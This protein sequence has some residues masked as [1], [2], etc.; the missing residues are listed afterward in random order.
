MKVSCPHC[1]AAYHVDDHRIPASGA[2][3]RCP[4]CRGTFPVRHVADGEV[5]GAVPLPA[6]TGVPAPAAVTF[7]AGTPPDR[8]PL[9]APESPSASEAPARGDDDWSVPLPAPDGA[10][11]SAI[12][13]S[14]N[15]SAGEPS[16]FDAAPAEPYGAAEPSDFALED[17]AVPLPEPAERSYED[18]FAAPAGP[19]EAAAPTAFGDIELATP[20]PGALVPPPPDDPFAPPPIPR[21]PPLR[22]A[23]PPATAP[24]PGDDLEALFGEE[25]RGAAAPAAPAPARAFAGPA[26]EPGATLLGSAASR[27]KVR[28]SSGRVFG[29]FAEEQIADML[30]KGE[31]LGNE[32]VS[33]D[34]GETW[35]A[36][37]SAAA[38]ADLLQRQHAAPVISAPE[39]PFGDR[40]GAPKVASSS[41]GRIALGRRA[42]VWIAAGALA[43]AVVGA[44]TWA[45][46]TGRLGFLFGGGASAERVAGFLAQ[47]RAALAKDDFA[48]E[49]AALDLAARALALDEDDLAARALYAEAAAALLLGHGAPAGA[50]QRAAGHAA[51]LAKDAAGELPALV[52]GLA[53]ALPSGD[54]DALARAETA[55]ERASARGAPAP[56]VVALLGRA[57]LLR[58]DGARAEALFAR[59][60]GLEANGVR[61][62]RGRGEAALLRGAAAEAKTFFEQALARDA[63][64][65]RSRL[66]LAAIAE[67]AGDAV[68]VQKELDRVLA[69]DAEGRLAPRERAR[70][71]AL[72]GAALGQ[73]A[74]DSAAADQAYQAAIA[75]D[76]E[77]HAARVALARL[78]LRRNDPAGAV[79]ALDPVAAAAAKSPEVAEVRIT[80]LAQAGRVLD[81]SQLAT[82]ALAVNPGDPALLLAQASVLECGDAPQDAVPVY[83]QAAARVPD[84]FRPQL[85]LGRLALARG[86]LGIAERT[87][88]A[89]VEKGP[90][91][92][93]T[94]AGLAALRLAQG[95]IAA[96]QTGFE[97]ALARDAEFAP[98]QLGLAKLALARGD[99]KG[100]RLALERAL[101]VD[102]RA[103]DAQLLLGTLLW[104]GGDLAAA[105]K[106]FQS[107]S[108]T[109]PKDAVALTRLGATRLEGGKVDGALQ[110][111]QSAAELDVRLAEA[112]HWL[113][114][115]LL[116]KG[117]SP[118][119]VA[120]LKR[121]LELEP[122][123]AQHHLHLGIALERSNALVEAI[124]TYRAAAQVDPKLV[125]AHERIAALY[126]LHGRCEEALS[127]YKA[128][129]AIAPRSARIRVG[130][131]DCLAKLGRHPEAVAIYQD[132]LRGEPQRADVPYRLAR[133]LHEGEGVGP[134]LPWYERAA[135]AEQDNPMPHYYL[136]YAFK[137]RGQRARAIQEFK[138]YLAK[139]P[140]AEDRKDI[141]AEIEDLGGKI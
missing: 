95:D 82:A 23:A 67:A 7:G 98:A 133:A 84:D 39:V 112:Q 62:P 40:M 130:Q 105:E 32:D 104:K 135:R 8:V 55:L 42:A 125:E 2:N 33:T 5:G 19:A 12:A 114:R 4:K 21:P 68:V 88:L 70:A 139:R 89:A 14:P 57:S 83:D 122:G 52:A 13:G 121:A 129:L 36:I 79:A 78:R 64:H 110:A 54:A 73:K 72:R 11:R 86:D 106:A 49:R 48:S 74:A 60:E 24:G 123:N 100:G 137:V 35:V 66:A 91:R 45:G 134:A 41:A 128:A 131:A 63:G 69:P 102:P 75:A 109:R 37:G 116:A 50:E 43:L 115:A 10:E 118:A 103:A 96:A 17:D 27:Y 81:A 3:V 71:L 15:S 94:H 20:P 101:A 65:V 51:A 107:A 93:E 87:L 120:R 97:T 92:P 44:G 28:R 119:A 127:A 111:L 30:Q 16:A 140:D 132:V 80:A 31:L 56:E 9:P 58:R 6:P 38:F 1:T 117:E 126:A 46:V 53:L 22:S 26:E 141:E 34:G 29:P 76:P 99:E 124:D 136:G 85:G 77:D 113:G 47:A 108:D 59:L 138:A 18:P 61:A 90:A 25:P